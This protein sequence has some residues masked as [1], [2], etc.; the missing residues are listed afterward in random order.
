MTAAAVYNYNETSEVIKYLPDPTF[1]SGFRNIINKDFIIGGLFPVYDCRDS[2]LEDLEMLEAML[3]AIDQINNDMNLLPNLTIGYD[4]RDSCNDEVIGLNEVLDFELNYDRSNNISFLGIV[5]PAYTSVTHSVATLLSLGIIEMPLISY[6]STDAALSNKDLYRY[7]LR[8][9]PSDTLQ[10][11]AIVDLVSYFG[12]EYVSVIFNDNDYG[13]S[14]SNAFID[15]AT[16]CSICIDAKIPIL[17]SMP[18]ET[19]AEAVKSLLESKAT[20]VIVF[21]D[22]DT[23]VELLVELIEELNKTNS[24]RK[25]VWIASDR[26]AN[27]HLVLENFTEIAKGMYAFQPHINCVKEFDDYFSQLIPSTN[28]RNPFFHDPQ[29]NEIYYHL[30]CN[31]EG[32][33]NGSGSGVEYDCPD[34]LTVKPGYS[35]GYN[36]PHVID[37]VYAFTHALQNFLDFGCDSPI[38]WNRTAQ[39][40]DGM[41]YPLTGKNFLGYLLNVTFYGTQNH[42][43]S[44]DENGDPSGVYEISNLQINE[45]GEYEYVRVGF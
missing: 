16:G 8:T 2:N 40:C 1:L 11:N 42:T 35:Q 25:F 6:A 37:A 33:G 43:M 36:V 41:K 4:V 19:I 7:L 12:W 14:A 18:N 30:Y 39:L 45:N 15:I 3:F 32:S 20:G 34:D 27:L 23:I 24:T 17:S 28:V 5:G 22:E 29:Y 9:I 44:F 38:R 21:T 31:T 26:W 13:V 10:T